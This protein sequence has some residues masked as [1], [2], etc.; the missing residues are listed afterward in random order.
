MQNC[1]W[2]VTFKS[3]ATK[4]VYVVPLKTLGL[5]NVC[6]PTAE[7]NVKISIVVNNY[8]YTLIN[9]CHNCILCRTKLISS[10]MYD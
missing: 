1:N 2:N 7:T 4:E 9:V 10:V 8:I 6:I 3:H 5:T